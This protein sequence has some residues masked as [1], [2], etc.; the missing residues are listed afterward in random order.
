MI[1]SVGAFLFTYWIAS[2]ILCLLVLRIW[3]KSSRDCERDLFF[4]T[5]GLGPIAISWLLYH[6]ILV[7]PGDAPAWYVAEVGA[8]FAVGLY[9]GRKQIGE[10]VVIY[11]GLAHDVRKHWPPSALCVVLALLIGLV[12]A[13]ILII[14]VGFPIVEGDA[15]GFAFEARLIRRDLSFENYPTFSPDPVTGYYYYTFQVPCLQMM[16]VWFSLLTGTE[17]VDYLPRTVAPVYCIYLVLLLCWV[18]LRQR[19]ALETALWGSL[20][21]IATPLLAVESYLNTQDPHRFFFSFAALVLLEA[22][23]RFPDRRVAVLL[24]VFT[25]LAIYAHFLG[26]LALAAVLLLYMSFARVTLLQRIRTAFLVTVLATLV[27]APLHYVQPKVVDRVMLQFPAVSRL[28]DAGLARI[29][30]NTSFSAH[31]VS[32]E[33]IDWLNARRGQAGWLKELVFGKLQIFTGIEWFGMLFWGFSAAALLWLSRPDKLLLESVLLGS[34]GIYLIAVLSDVRLQASSN[35]R[36]VGTILPA[37][38]YFCGI[39]STSI[40]RGSRQRWGPIAAALAAGVVIVLSVGPLAATAGVRGAKV[41]I[42]NPGNLYERIRS[43]SWIETVVRHPLQALE[44]VRTRYLGIAETLRYLSASDD[45]KLRHAHDI[46]AAVQFMNSSTPQNARALV[47]RVT[48]YFYYAQRGG[49]SYLDPRMDEF[50]AIRGRVDACRYLA[51]L[52]VDHVIVDSYYT[53]YPLY[54]DTEL[55]T[56]LSD[57]YLSTS[58][59]RY[60]EAGVYKLHCDG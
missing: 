13:F 12:A 26:F 31:P 57:S 20:V 28:V 21:L 45:E 60:G 42:S 15:L 30:W 58:V 55:A 50:A 40:V 41:G 10:L 18:L 24:G 3:P 33:V 4:L 39:L 19:K 23:L 43:L 29:G 6:L 37:C 52:G 54:A 56:I 11:S 36:Y 32:G 49:I 9:F 17:A 59:Y 34:A 48:P 27:G 51:S 44:T 7:F 35:P 16:Y 8:F 53:S 22:L 5:R 47:F 2:D 1:V 14:G 25:G 46:F 38:A